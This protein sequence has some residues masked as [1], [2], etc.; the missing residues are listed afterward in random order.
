[1]AGGKLSARQK[2]INLMYLVF[3]AMLA[4]NMGKKVLSSFGYLNEKLESSNVSLASENRAVLRDLNTKA[5]EQ[6]EKY[7]AL[8]SIAGQV[9]ELSDE[10]YGYLQAVKD[11]LLKAYGKDSKDYE[12]MDSEAYGDA[13]F[14]AGGDKLTSNGKQFVAKIN[15][16]R[17]E[18]LAALEGSI[19]EEIRSNIRK[20]F[21]A[22]DQPN[23]DKSIKTKQPWIYNR[24]E[25][26]PLV[27]TMTNLSVLQSDVKTTEKEIYNFLLGGQ[28]SRDAGVNENTYKTIVIPKKPAFFAG[29]MFEGTIA[30]GRYDASLKPEKVVVNGREVKDRENGAALVK[31]RA[32]N[33][34]EN[35]IE[36]NF[37]FKQDGSIVNIPIK[38]SYLVIPKPNAAAVSA[39]KMNVVYRGVE[40]PMTISLPGVSDNNVRAS[41]PGLKRISGSKYVL[42]PGKGK[43]VEIKV[44]GTTNDGTLI[45]SPPAQFRIKDIPPPSVS[46]RG[47]F[48]SLSMPKTSLL[49]TKI[50]VK[51]EDFDFD[52]KF[53]VLEFTLKVPGQLSVVVKGNRMD[54]RALKVLSKAKIGDV[55]TIFDVKAQIEG[56]SKYQLKRPP[57]PIRVTINN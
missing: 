19:D 48:G 56:D 42:K 53:K 50:R 43:T 29:E 2:M 10:Y 22:S 16:Y 51:M 26:F 17:Q 28:L 6:R 36:G 30:L 14:F 40:N 11:A 46:I 3:I 5:S 15:A 12:S 4:L 31:F 33:V 27:A 20:R 38:D 1:M 47:K 35:P 25:G 24:Y 37:V 55:V 54:M 52:L 44:S 7:A 57:Y 39:D 34:G 32:G 18:V 21:D 13:Y 8:D 41:A 9:S 45:K 23:P 49:K